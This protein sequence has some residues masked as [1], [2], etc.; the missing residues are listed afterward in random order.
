MMKEMI[1]ENIFREKYQKYQ[2]A[3]WKVVGRYFSLQSDKEDAFQEVF[4]RMWSKYPKHG[5]SHPKEEFSWVMKV[6]VTTSI[7]IFK[8]KKSKE[9]IVTVFKQLGG[10]RFHSEL[11]VDDSYYI[12]EPLNAEQRMI[13]VLK[14]LEGYR[15]DE[16]ATMMNIKIGTVKSRLNRAKLIARKHL[17]KRGESV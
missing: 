17:E 6:A 7:N 11:D 9:K 5:F 16:I 2:R 12:L 4:V 8:A 15:Y 13:L 14:E 3:V 10:H 1:E